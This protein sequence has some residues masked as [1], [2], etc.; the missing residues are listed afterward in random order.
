ME[1]K[2]SA[3]PPAE[4]I[5]LLV[6][7]IFQLAGAFRRLGEEVANTVSHTQ[8]QWQVLS[9]CS[10]GSYT[11]A[12][13]ARRLGY[14]RQS[15]QRTADQL[16]EDGLAKYVTNPDHKASPLLE[17]NGQ[18]M[19]IFTQITRAARKW[20]VSLARGLDAHRLEV[21]LETIRELCRLV[22]AKLSQPL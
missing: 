3:R 15:V 5:P 4:L 21:T 6:A 10:A 2:I 14:A 17:L 9:V 18:G 7:D 13:I 19:E 1:G 16:V 11:V 20:H 22:E 12:Q 8:S